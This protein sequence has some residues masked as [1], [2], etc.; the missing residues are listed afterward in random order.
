[1]FVYNVKLNSKN[2]VK[3]SLIIISIIVV[4]FFLLSLHKILSSTFNVDDAV[5]EPDVAYLKASDYA[6]V[7]KSVY[8]NLDTYIGQKICF[9]GYVYRNIDFSE[10]QFVLA[11]D[12][13]IEGRAEA[14][15]VGFLC[16]H[17]EA[18][19]YS[20]GTWVEITGEI[21]KG[22][23]HGD[24]PII[25]VKEIKQIDKPE[26]DIYAYPPDDSY[27]PTSVIF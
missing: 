24:M 8:E 15:I 1:M 14:L 2:V 6:N 21:T 10:T 18:S 27:V 17:K 13:L 12:M 11:R 4:I 3:I 20:D 26:E 22:N 19:T 25:K 9:S 23:Y 16:S 5:P 7:L